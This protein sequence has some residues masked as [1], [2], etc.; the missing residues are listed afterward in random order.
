MHA[1]DGTEKTIAHAD[2]ITAWQ[3]VMT[4][5]LNPMKSAC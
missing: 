5:E 1:C 4:K 2:A 3:G